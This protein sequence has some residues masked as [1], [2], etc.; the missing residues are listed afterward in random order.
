MMQSTQ[1]NPHNVNNAICVIQSQS[2]ST[3]LQNSYNGYNGYNKMVIAIMTTTKTKTLT[4]VMITIIA[5]IVTVALRSCWL[6]KIS[7]VGALTSW[8]L[9]VAHLHPKVCK[10]AHLNIKVGRLVHLH[11]KAYKSAYL[12]NI[13]VNISQQSTHLHLRNWHTQ[14]IFYKFARIYLLG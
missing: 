3:H 9:K 2:Q 11:F 14:S 8:S 12:L 13:N 7:E 4:T 1:Y 5:I 6:H 10:S